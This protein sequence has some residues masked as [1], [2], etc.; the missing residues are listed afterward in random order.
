MRKYEY[1][2]VIITKLGKEINHKLA[3]IKSDRIIIK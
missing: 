1:G 2:K 3:V